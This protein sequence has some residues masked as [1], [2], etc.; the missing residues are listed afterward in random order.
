MC[1]LAGILVFGASG[2]TL[3]PDQ[4]VDILDASI[5]QRGPDGWGRFRDRTP[6]AE[7][8]LAHRRLS[9]LDHEGGA[10]PMV[11][12]LPGADEGGARMQR[13]RHA[14]PP[15]S[16]SVQGRDLLAVVFNGCI[17]NH[18]SLRDQL[19]AAG[20]DFASDH[21]DT[22][23]LLHATRA[24]AHALADR[25]DGMYA[26]AIWSQ[27]HN[28]LTLARDPSGE[29]PLYLTRWTTEA[30][31]YLA[32]GSTVAG[33]LTLRQAA[34]VGNRPDPVGVAMW[35]KHGYWP[36]MPV[37][38]VI[39][40]APGATYV[41][42]ESSPWPPK[43]AHRVHVEGP[44]GGAPLDEHTL[45]PM[46]ERA[47]A[48]RLEADVPIGCFLSGG[49]DSSVVAALAQRA[50]ESC[51]RRLQTF[52]V[53][54][55]VS[56]FDES[57]YARQVAAHLGTDHEELTCRTSAAED[58]V[59]LIEQLGLPFGDSSLLPTHWVSAAARE[60][61][62]VALG[63]DGGDELFGGYDRYQLNASLHR[64][65]GA[66]APL[67][68]APRWARGIRLGGDLGRVTTAARHAG[69]D[70]ILTILRSP[71]LH[72]LLGA[73]QGH[74]LLQA[75]YAHRATTADARH[76]DYER[77]LPMD[78]MR[79]VDTASMAVALEVRAPFLER[80]LVGA[81]LAA[82]M[83]AVRAGEGPKGLLR[84]IAR[85]LVPAEAID[86]KKGGFGIPLGQW[87]REDYAGM[88]GLLRETL[89]RG[90]AFD[91]VGLEVRQAGVDT[92]MEEH[93]AGRRDHG[94]RLYSLLVLALW[95]RLL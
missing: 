22:E 52:N 93:F 77:Y 62:K 69:Y 90:D 80:T 84:Q 94:K 48:S 32:F 70:D 21:S 78:L 41:L 71:H 34:G 44:A 89:G 3:I 39:E 74:R 26:Y 86:R 68:A 60:H 91:R 61:V 31:T 64:W 6:S 11:S 7:I 43:E 18:R 29:K 27:A 36:V 88:Q 45:M 83:Q 30:H 15:E 14:G 85:S 76:D 35:L 13:A 47:V 87:F 55:P 46:L 33:L 5:A 53:Q 10:Q 19:Q 16:L 66:L 23:V 8:A 63:G 57:P 67:R 9:I 2:P 58:L 81:A 1:G 56:R 82:P 79:K 25:L 73:E 4:W 38:D 12:M 37:L 72:A 42:D 40:A 24:H 59:G 17:Y 51:G 50:L 54:M 49:V 20:H 95:G 92:L 65:R 75:G 28:T